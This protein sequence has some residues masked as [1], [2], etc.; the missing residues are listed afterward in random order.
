M[1]LKTAIL[2]STSI[3]ILAGAAPAFAQ[4]EATPAAQADTAP[5][6]V[7]A[8]DDSAEDAIVVTGY[9]RSLESAQNIKRQSE[10]I[11]DAIVAEDIGKLPDITASAALARVTG[12]QVNRSAG[13]AA[14]VQ[15][16]GLPDISTTYNGREI[17][18][19]E[20]RFVAIQDF[21]AGAVAALEVYKSGTSNLV[22]GG[23]GGQV[24]VRSRRPFD[25]DGFHLS[26]SAH[27]VHFEQSQD[28]TWN[29]NLLVSDRWNTGIG[30]FGALVNVAMTNIQYLDATRENDRYITP[31]PNVTPA[32]GDF[33]R[34]NGQGIFYS[35]GDRWRPSVNGALQWRPSPNLEF[36]VDGLF[37]GYRGHDSNMWMFVPTFGATQFS[38]VVLRD[39]GS[40]SLQS[41]TVT[42][43]AT[44]DGY[45]EFRDAKTDTYQVAGGFIWSSGGLKITG[46]VAY[47]DSTY[48]ESQANIDYALSS[49][50]VRNVNFDVQDGHGG[51]TF[52]FLN[53]NSAD[54]AN[55]LWRGLFDRSY[56]AAGDD[57]QGRL[58]AQ[59]ETGMDWLSRIDLGVRYNDRSATRSNGGRYIN[60]LGRGIGLS[61]LPVEIDQYPRGFRF[62]KLQPDTK[63]PA[64][65]FDSVFDNIDALRTLTGFPT[66]AT[67][68]EPLE[69]FTA[70]EKVFAGYAQVR[71]GFDLGIPVD[72]TIGLRAVHTETTLN[73]TSRQNPGT[74]TEVTS[75]IIRTNKYWDYLPSAN[76]RFGLAEK[77]QL[78]LAYTKTRTRPNFDQLNPGG[79]LGTPPGVCT[80]GGVDNVN[81]VVDYNGGNPDLKPLT[82]TNYD[83]SLEYYF[84]RT[85]LVSLAAFR[86]DTNNFIF[87]DQTVLEI[88]NAPNVRG[89][90]P[91]NGGKGRI[92]GIE[93]QFTTFLDFES[94]PNW[95][96][97]FG[98]QAN[99]TYIDAGTE[100]S[101]TQALQ[102]PG[103]QPVPFVS[104]HSYNL[105]G[106]YESGPFSARLAYNWRSDF[107]VEYQN[108]QANFLRPL[109]Q[110]SLGTLDFS[111]SINPTKNVT[112]AFDLLNILAQPIKT[113]RE[114]NT[115][116]DSYR[117]QT[118]YLERV[119][120]L[121]VRFRF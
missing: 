29:G 82:S 115:A 57:I 47:T 94:L 88:P 58:D 20:N 53:F 116:G 63:F 118:K 78:R 73:G 107:V 21:P 74:G 34:P 2:A 72:G 49:S 44:P 31:D 27:G 103:Q 59:Y 37:Q 105:V 39:D 1:R 65:T 66:G 41:A 120:S 6:E 95:A 71:Y 108:L 30:E 12:V 15:V 24:N 8:Q 5:A 25:F 3:L 93:A 67:P 55:Y 19:A 92:Q 36:Y 106:M 35:R 38:N 48:T 28:L 81:C 104:E 77:L 121:G 11:V 119:Y 84:S 102:L 22:E 111:A 46:D 83:A 85:G 23:I 52:D 60:T 32:P 4:T 54:P 112:V 113:Y 9:R 43:A 117:F 16:R 91:F 61:A 64:P 89:N 50:P 99:Y 96:H 80:T 101:P 90:L 62:D 109:Y 45:Y 26:G 79:F 75:P 70:S 97:G 7:T 17:F 40:R 76:I 68:Y 10:G 69:T 114:Y 100:L 56:M 13:E 51:G 42:N 33:V 98:V 86:R 87:R 18:T 14:Q 110:D